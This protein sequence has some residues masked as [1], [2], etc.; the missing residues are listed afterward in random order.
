VTL[1]KSSR[2]TFSRQFD[3]G[4]PPLAIRVST[5][6][7]QCPALGASI[8]PGLCWEYAMVNHGGPIDSVQELQSRLGQS[9]RV[10]TI[11]AFHRVCKECIHCSWSA[12]S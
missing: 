9:Q 11:E 6:V 10:A 3:G 4:F 12:D 1:S 8:S 5:I 2:A 7:I